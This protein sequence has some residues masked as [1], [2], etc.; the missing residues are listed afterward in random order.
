MGG[1]VTHLNACEHVVTRID[2]FTAEP[3]TLAIG[4]LVLRSC[5]N[6]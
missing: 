6:R 5:Y 2:L 4:A 1:S 3:A